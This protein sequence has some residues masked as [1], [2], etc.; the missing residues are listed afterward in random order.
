MCNNAPE[1]L[2]WARLNMLPAPEPFFRCVPHT[3]IPVM[4]QRVEAWAFACYRSPVQ[5][6]P[7]QGRQGAAGRVGFSQIKMVWGLRRSSLLGRVG[8]LFSLWRKQGKKERRKEDRK[9]GWMDARRSSV[10]SCFPVQNKAWKGH[11]SAPQQDPPQ[12]HTCISSSL[13]G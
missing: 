3:I 12:S 13:P 4:R 11:V 9:E 6:R 2:C 10:I 1:C 5:E 7:A 8:R